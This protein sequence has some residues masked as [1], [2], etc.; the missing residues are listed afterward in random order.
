VL[1]GLAFAITFASPFFFLAIF[2]SLL[3]KMPKSGNWLNNVKVIMGF[4]ELAA[5][6][7]FLR[8]GELV[9]L[10]TPTFFTFDLVLGIWVALCLLCGLYLL[11]VYRLPHDTPVEHLTVPR[12]MFAAIFLSLGFYLL[13]A[14][15]KHDAEGTPQRPNGAVYAWIDSFLLPDPQEGKGELEWGGSL[16]EA[17]VEARKTPAGGKRPLVF[18]DF[19]GKTCTNC[20]I[21]ERSVFSKPDIKALFKPYKLVQLYTDQVPNELYPKPVREKFGND[22]SKQTADA[23]VNLWF[24]FAAFQTEQ[25]P[26]YVILE[27]MPDGKIRV[28]GVYPEGRINDE[29]AF[30]KFLKEPLAETTQVASRQ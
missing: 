10:P 17:L 12:L 28:V 2:P 21:N 30:A 11:N 16:R 20:R 23:G 26:L 8:A 14:L 18:I 5:A 24:Q 27:P 29:A 1:G 9:L 13:P 25:L 15:F 19:T 6:L 7:K 3:K 22:V 4:L